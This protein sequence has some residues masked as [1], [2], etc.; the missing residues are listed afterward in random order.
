MVR[1]MGAEGLLQKRRVKKNHN[2][3]DLGM[4]SRNAE[5]VYVNESLA[6]GRCRVLNAAQLAKKDNGYTYLQIRSGKI[7]EEGY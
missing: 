7:L 2:T 6:P 1:R 4:T 5:V 3:R